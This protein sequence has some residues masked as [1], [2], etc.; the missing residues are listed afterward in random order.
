[1]GKLPR[2]LVEDTLLKK[3]SNGDFVIR[4]SEQNQGAYTLVCTSGHA[5]RNDRLLQSQDGRWYLQGKVDHFRFD[6]IPE[7]LE[8]VRFMAKRP[9]GHL[10]T[11]KAPTT[12]TK[13][14]IR[15]EATRA[16][17]ASG[18]G[19][20]P[21]KLRAKYPLPADPAGARAGRHPRPCLA[22]FTFVPGC[23]CSACALAR[24]RPLP[25]SVYTSA[26]ARTHARSA[27]RADGAKVP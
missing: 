1:M 4:E 27:L 12:Q 26:H 3:G 18:S 8:R 23:K 17:P 19:G 24:T 11:G 2:K 20:S 6:T 9:V 22:D 5:I 7:L 15:N 25:T 14:N 16:L 13:H 21:V 10:L